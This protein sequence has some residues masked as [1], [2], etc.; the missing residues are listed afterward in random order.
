MSQNYLPMRV[1]VCA[2]RTG[3]DQVEADKP[4]M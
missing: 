1:G 3:L 2:T 4:Q